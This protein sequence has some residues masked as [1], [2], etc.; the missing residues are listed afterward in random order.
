FVP[1]PGPEPDAPLYFVTELRGTIKVVTNDRTVRTF[2]T[3][4]TVGFQDVELRGSSQ[5]GLAGLCLDPR[6]GHVFV[7]FTYPDARGILRNCIGR[8]RTP[9]GSFGLAP[10][11]TTD[12]GPVL[13]DFQAAPAHQI[14][15]CVVRG[16]SLYVGV[17]DGGNVS[18]AS[19][20]NVLLGKV[21]RLSVDGTAP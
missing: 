19:N 2:A 13:A 14:G 17:G 1:E 3:V 5:Q 6:R 20:V 9:P 4:P 10:D 12:F 21:L 18:S 11:E 7:T 8:F 16:D 15:G